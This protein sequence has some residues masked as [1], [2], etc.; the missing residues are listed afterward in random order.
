MPEKRESST[1]TKLDENHGHLGACHIARRAEYLL[2]VTLVTMF[3]WR[4][5]IPAWS[6]LDTDFPNYYLAARLYRQ[7]YPV[8]KLYDWI[9]IARQ[10]DHAEI[11]RPVIDFST[12]T[13]PSILTILPFSWLPPLAA[14]RAWL[15][16]TLILLFCAAWL[17]NQMTNL[18][19]RR[20]ALITFLA[21]D[22]LRMNFLYGQLYVLML[23]LLALA[24][25]FFLRGR[26]GACGFTLALGSVI[27]I[28]PVL[29]LFY[30]ATKR[31]W[32]AVLGMILGL[33][34][35]AMFSLLLFG[36]EANRAYAL[37]ILP[38]A[39]RGEVIDPYSVEWNS[40]TAFL[41]R[42]FIAE[43]D[44]NPQPLVFSPSTYAFLQPLCMAFLLVCFLWAVSNSRSG[45]AKLEWATLPV[46]LLVL[47]PV[48]GSYH[49]CM[50]ILGVVLASDALLQ[51]G[52]RGYTLLILVIYA[53]ACLPL[54]RWLAGFDSSWKIFL[55]FP[56]L[57]AMIAL[58]GLL[59]WKLAVS[60]AQPSGLRSSHSIGF[61]LLFVCITVAGTVS[62]LRHLRGQFTNYAQRL[63]INRDSLLS[64]EPSVVGDA[65]FF[66][67]M[68]P[69]GYG[70]DRLARGV[71]TNFEFGMDTF[72]STV[73]NTAA[74]VWVELASTRSD[75]VRFSPES[76]PL[77]MNVEVQNAE[78]PS[79]SS[80]G[81]WLAFI[82]EQKG[83]GSLLVKDLRP[84]H[85]GA[86]TN[87]SARELADS[88]YDVLE[89]AFFPDGRVI[90]AAEP[91]GRPMLFTANA[92]NPG[93]ALRPFLVGAR[94]PAV[95]PDGA[96]LAYSEEEGGNWQVWTLQLPTGEKRRL[97]NGDCNSVTPAW[98]PDSRTVIYATDCGRGLGL[99]ALAEVQGVP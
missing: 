49:H 74:E 58:T 77:I 75:I 29:F 6:S 39:L 72:H 3:V 85:L 22:P 20:V 57:Y 16:V 1:A 97:T 53:V 37:E 76:R 54:Y 86:P 2:L 82:R 27:K 34:A 44:L 45:S 47:S 96:W 50:L 21:V 66:T 10:K 33:S 25:W 30:F 73:G 38:R 42:L 32:R 55:A 12:G 8:N 46:L 62:N 18:G 41:R 24:A 11:E 94:Y 87:S 61:G 43:P 19:A 31:Q 14:K 51:A 35:L 81:K 80:D 52:Q 40:L 65:I 26:Q 98:R 78:Q 13:L 36:Y 5:L 23:A 69:R 59:L 7:G 64:I 71:K 92:A 48:L 90:F 99:T 89:A 88:H 67:A 15:F 60:A 84:D 28:Y 68:A 56:R 17:M 93:A 79:V 9:W 4:G 95:S 70:V 91:S 83:K 63:T